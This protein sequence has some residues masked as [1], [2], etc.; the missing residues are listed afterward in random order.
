MFTGPRTI[1]HYGFE[2]GKRREGKRGISERPRMYR[3]RVQFRTEQVVH[4]MPTEIETNRS[5]HQGIG[6]R[7]P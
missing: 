3:I 1:P 2:S 4:E 5:G 7:E 6:F